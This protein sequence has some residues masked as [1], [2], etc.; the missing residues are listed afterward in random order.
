MCECA[1]EFAR[2]LLDEE[3]NNTWPDVLKFLFECASSPQIRAQGQCPHHLWGLSR[4][5]F[6]SQQAQYLDVI[7]QMLH[8]C[9]TDQ[10][11]AVVRGSAARAA[12]AF[13]LA[14]DGEAGV[15]AHL[16]ELLPFIIQIVTDSV[17]RTDDDTLLKCNMIDL[18]EN[19]PK[20]LRPSSRCRFR[21]LSEGN[22]INQS[23]R[24]Y[25]PFHNRKKASR[26]PQ[27]PELAK[28]CHPHS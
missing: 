16:K 2:N 27:K 5:I 21:P 25:R 15:L 20:F 14:N 19:V 18:A 9:L 23:I 28:P 11:D 1:A 26:T 3:G 4:G 24:A 17:L 12:V 13:I 6:G 7:K 8:Q 10:S 22:L